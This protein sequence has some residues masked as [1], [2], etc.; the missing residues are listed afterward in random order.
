Q[1][2]E[3]GLVHFLAALGVNPDTLRLR[4]AP[5]YS[6]LLSSLVY[7]VGVLAAEAFLPSE[8]RGKQRAA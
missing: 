1:P 5:K 8:Q 4:T 6:S 2:F 3:S 7:G